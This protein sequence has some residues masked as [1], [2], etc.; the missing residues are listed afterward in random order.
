MMARRAAWRC[1]VGLAMSFMGCGIPLE[2]GLTS[3]DNTC[4]SDGDCGAAALCVQLGAQARC[5]ARSA[6]LSRVLLEVRPA[7]GTGFVANG[8][9]LFDLGRLSSGPVVFT[10]TRPGG[11]MQVFS[12][13]LAVALP[14]HGVVRIK[15]SVD[16][17][18]SPLDASIP[19]RVALRRVAAFGGLPVL[20][21]LPPFSVETE[22]VVQPK[23]RGAPESAAYAFDLLVPP[24]DYEVY[25]TPQ[26]VEGCTVSPPP[27]AV[28]PAR[29]IDADHPFLLDPLEPPS[30]LSVSI[31]VPNVSDIA[32][33]V[34][35]LVE[36]TEGRLISASQ[37]LPRPVDGEVHLQA[38]YYWLV[39]S[40]A[41]I[42]RLRPP[43][44]NAAPTVYWQLDVV[45]LGGTKDVKLSLSDLEVAPLEL[46]GQVL[47]A[48]ARPV[49]G[50]AVTIQSVKLSG[51]VARNGSY[52]LSTQTDT[53]GVFHAKLIPG[54]YSVVARPST[55]AA[56]SAIAVAE[57]D[58]KTGDLCCGRTL[59]LPRLIP[60]QG[61]ALTAVGQP[62]IGANIVLSPSTPK[63][64]SFLVSALGA[65]FLPRPTSALADDRGGFVVPADPGSFDLS[66]RPSHEGS[67]FPWLVRSRLTVHEGVAATDIG[68]LTVAY[69]AILAGA[70]FGP[71]GKPVSGAS[72]RAWLP[73]TDASTADGFEGT[74]VEIG[75]TTTA[76][77]GDYRLS[78][79]PSLSQ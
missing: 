35:E 52:K 67:G 28:L 64:M 5:V 10:G 25:I 38:S 1:T 26:S 20:D 2:S 37:R 40:G 4:T 13:T 68:V 60:L 59:A 7:P 53:T 18:Q 43:E 34:F 78:L 3:L 42:L 79:P 44:G 32:S 73:V 51:S 66:V 19:A 47:D 41:P 39:G 17:C 23:A 14:V 24:D 77:S 56:G 57:W 9:S 46:E 29:R 71:D 61:V 30:Q 31:A 27:P 8:S 62:L 49:L 33:W 16:A 76:A 75:E 72:V 22:A 12:P 63:P 15:P 54:R 45:D 69:P 6:D 58:I 36:P 48:A 21:G 70:V 74:V 55:S 50:A 11:Q 65:A